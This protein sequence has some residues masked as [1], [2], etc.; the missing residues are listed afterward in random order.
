MT[1]VSRRITLLFRVKQGALFA[2]GS[3]SSERLH[4]CEAKR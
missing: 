4:G 3:L 2:E 1:R